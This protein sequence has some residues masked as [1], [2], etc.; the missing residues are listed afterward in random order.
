MKKRAMSWL[1]ALALCLTLLPTAALAEE[2]PEPTPEPTGQGET[3]PA[4]AAPGDEDEQP[5][6]PEQPGDE[7]EQ[8]TQPKEPEQPEQEEATPAA[9][10][11]KS[12][13]KQTDGALAA[14]QEQINALPTDVTAENADEIAARLVAID[15]AL[16]ALTEEQTAML[17]MARYEALCEALAAA[18]TVQAAAEHSHTLCSHLDD[19]PA[20]DHDS[21]HSGAVDFETKLTE[22]VLTSNNYTLSSGNYYLGDWLSPEKQIKITGKVTICLNGMPIR[23]FGSFDVFSVGEGAELTITDCKN[24]GTITHYSGMDYT[25]CGVNVYKGTFNLY[26]GS[27]TGNTGFVDGDSAT[28]GGVYVGGYDSKAGTFNM[29]G[30]SITNNN[31]RFGGGVRVNGSD[32]T[33]NLYGGSISGNTTQNGSGG[34]VYVGSARSVGATFHM[35]GGSITGNTVQKGNGGGVFVLCNGAF[36]MSGG[37]IGGTGE[38]DANQTTYNGGGV[39]VD[40][41]PGVYT[42]FNMSGTAK[43]VGNIANG[44]GGGVVVCSDYKG[45]PSTFTMSDN[46]TVT[47]NVAKTR[48]GGGVYASGAFTMSGNAAVTGNSAAKKEGGGVYVASDGSL[49][50]SGSAAV[51][52]NN[53]ASSGGGVYVEYSSTNK[54]AG[55]FTVSGA[56]KVEKNWKNGTLSGDVYEQ[57]SGRADNILLNGSDTAIT[58]AVPLSDGASLYINKESLSGAT[59]KAVA[60]NAEDGAQKYFHT[61]EPLS[62]YAFTWNGEDSTVVL[63]AAKHDA[64]PLCD[65]ANCTDPAHQGEHPSVEFT[66]P[67][68]GVYN[69]DPLTTG[70]YFL[71]DDL[72]LSKTLTISGDVKLCLNGHS[73]VANFNNYAIT[74]DLNA[75]LSLADCSEDQTGTVTHGM[76]DDDTKYTSGGV[77][78][79][80]P[81]GS[82][83]KATTTF[84]LYGGSISGNTSSSWQGTGVYVSGQ[85][86]ST[87]TFNMY[88]GAV[89]GNTLGGSSASFGGG[90]FVWYYAAFNMYGGTISNNTAMR[91]G[92]GVYLRGGNNG[93]VFT[94]KGGSI[95][96]NT[97]LGGVY[98]TNDATGGGV[99]VENGSTFTVSGDAKVI[100]NV[101]GSAP[102]ST[103]NNVCLSK[104]TTIAINGD[105]LKGGAKFGII[106]YDTPSET[107]SVP[108][109]TGATDTKLD[110]ST[111]FTPDVTG[112]NYVVT[113]G[114]DGTLSLGIHQHDWTY[115]VSADGKT[116]SAACTA[117]G[118]P[119]TDGGS[120]TVSAA[121][122]PYDR[123]AKTATVTAS[124]DWQGTAVD[125]ITVTYKGVNG[126][127][128]AE[129]TTAPTNAGTYTASITLGG[130][131]ASTEYE[132]TKVDP[133]IS[134]NGYPYGKSFTGSKI[135]SPAEG[136]IQIHDGKHNALD[137]YDEITF[138]WYD[139]TTGAKLDEAPIDAGSYIIEAQF[140]ATENTNAVSRRQELTINKAAL[141][142]TGVPF[143]TTI[144]IYPAASERTYEY[145]LA[146]VM[147]NNSIRSGDELA[148]NQY[149]INCYGQVKSAVVEDG[150]VKITMNPV[151]Q[152]APGSHAGSVNV[153]LSSRNYQQIP[154]TFDME[155]VAKQTV[156]DLAVAMADWT[157]GTP[158]EPKYQAAAGVK[159]TVTYTKADGT[160][161]DAADLATAS[162]G[163][164]IVR[165]EY[166]T[167]TET[168]YGTA[169][170]AIS[171]KAL[172]AESI[173]DIADV[174]YTGSAIEPTVTV[175]DG[176]T[177]LVLDTDYTVAY[178][179]NTNA[180]T[181]KVTVTG[182]GNYTGD[183]VKNFTITPRLLSS[184]FDTATITKVYD[185]TTKSNLA[186]D[187]FTDVDGNVRYDLVK[188]KDYTLEAA[189]TDQNVPQNTVDC[190]INYTVELTNPNYA[191][192]IVGTNVRRTE[193]GTWGAASITPARQTITV[194]AGKTVTKNGKGVNI[195]DGTEVKGIAGGS[196]PG[197]LTYTLVASYADVTLEGTTLTVAKNATLSSITVKVAAAATQNYEAAEE[198][199]TVTL[200]DRTAQD[201]F[202]FAKNAEKKTYGD[203]AFTL[204]AEGAEEGSTVTYA[205]SNEEVATV[206]GNGKVT[207]RKAGTATITA[208]ASETDVY[209]EAVAS[210]DL[211]VGK[212]NITVTAE[213]QSTRVGKA[214][215]ELTYTYAPELV[216]GD[217]FSGA[218]ATTADKDTVGTYPITRGN[219]ALSD[220]YK[221]IFVDGTYTVTDKLTQDGF[222]FAKSTVEKIYGDAAF[223]F[224]ATGAATGSSVTYTS[225]DET[226]ATV[227]ENG[228][229]TILKAG[230][231]V[232]TAAA[233]GTAD[234]EAASVS[235][236]LTVAKKSIAIPEEDTTAFT[237]NG[238]PQTY[239]LTENEAYTITGNVQINANEAGYTVTVALKDTE[240]TQWADG[241]TAEKTY[242]FVISKKPIV[243]PKEDA[244]VFT[245]NGSEQTYALAEDAAYTIT[246]NVQ[247]NANETGYTVTVA[248]KDTDNTQWADGTTAD[249]T[250]SFVIK[251]AVVTITVKDQT[252]YVGD[253]APALDG[254]SYTVAGLIEGETLTTAPTVAYVG[255]PDM[256]KAGETAIRASGASAG[257]N[258][259]ITYVDGKLTVSAR[260]SGGGGGSS[261]PTYPV[262]TP[263][264]AD[265]GSIS[266]NVKNAAKGSTVTI[267][268]K[269]D[270]GYKLDGLT[271]TDSKGNALKLT[272]KGNGVYTFTMPEGK[273]EVS[274]A[275]AEE[276]AE[277]ASPFADVATNAYYFEAVKWA[278]DKGITGG[279]GN[280]LFG[281]NDPCTRGQIVTFLWRA[282]GS[283][284]PEDA[285]N[286]TDVAADSYCAKAVAWA[287]ENGITLGTTGTT[288]SPNASCTRAQGMAFL[289]RAVK[290]SAS[291]TSAFSDVAS[292]AYYAQAVK[293]ATDNGITNG[294]GNGLFGSNNPCTRA[295]IVTFLWRLYAGK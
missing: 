289:F 209:A 83:E 150:K 134:W 135:D 79:N 286:F 220:N 212:R 35:Y 59:S 246:G 139:A 182:R 167:D 105:G 157:Y 98:G 154:L 202:K 18:L 229:V 169:D 228:K 268:V 258:Y 129:S 111:I 108:F 287:V 263:S 280:S 4:P 127:T 47:G 17:D 62:N 168:H 103:A 24:S 265:N 22:E 76:K 50:M 284:E 279:K 57:G 36:T 93:A 107:D 109:A 179:D 58:I 291:G 7:D 201:N 221:L 2:T 118:C 288:F 72:I 222:K 184:V 44:F 73:I 54:T 163:S 14:V 260:P 238:Q 77:Y 196:E 26:G 176:E 152:I 234:Y 39:Y 271:V 122:A 175:K 38:N 91:Y 253:A 81:K 233:T 248:L 274:A 136:D 294:I 277:V 156:E 113:R 244:T 195:A 278:A 88:G 153:G 86:G 141:A 243:I 206:D 217:A 71:T 159:Y 198:T 164:Y 236:T 251:K 33:F 15:E 199:F 282:A 272:D 161:V 51:T 267:T 10:V 266:S 188:G 207:I 183:A 45:K 31:A 97:V 52:G 281:S 6:S 292:G 23:A 20:P 273:V 290:A 216:A 283:P 230:M 204:A 174:A 171:P 214:L 190:E 151:S 256:T 276:T 250:Y 95:S 11:R 96:G 110:Y 170:F 293:W 42:S 5:A 48:E 185:G 160:A 197:A 245:Y 126:T 53:S 46:A 112:Q 241:T 64:H 61:D 232:I 211:T 8:P 158:Q 70:S 261:A 285:A 100:G 239:T 186:I 257:E 94:M 43:I 123:T 142:G 106:T 223:D 262:N 25:G 213:N 78:V 29:Y 1:L 55:K 117:N 27:I 60:T 249:K 173:A 270:V 82:S 252:A 143:T 116:I 104:D 21:K 69:G 28:G 80:A 115:T 68:G 219:L 146:D 148:V 119:N 99:Y 275:F 181:A 30:G 295:Q 102:N 32:G 259:A 200:S 237:Y 125:S 56:A 194:P 215:D 264:K 210:Y 147:T 242:I 12:P 155:V 114:E 89:S 133:V 191:F 144:N 92:G 121:S 225:S 177:V 235:Y 85:S 180:G 254:E 178:A 149:G 131:T 90:V 203:E 145:S 128:Y 269:P 208:T 49:T 132:I 75:T 231:T 130:Q 226:V 16:E 187:Y 19:C 247:T 37:I 218:L 67:L 172:T 205:S 192:A 66:I 63:S 101:L 165:V 138:V 40:A 65:K 227:D 34:G 189:Y 224:A 84:N 124:D 120:V 137:L 41:T 87:T 9:E 3:V 193:E 13:W 162:V 255:D 240:N 74:V 166:E 140:K